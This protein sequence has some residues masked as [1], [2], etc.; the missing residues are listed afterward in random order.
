[1]LTNN[2]HMFLDIQEPKVFKKYERFFKTD[3]LIVV[4]DCW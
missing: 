3:G 1:M 4:S 2:L